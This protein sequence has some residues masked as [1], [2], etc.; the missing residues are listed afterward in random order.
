MCKVCIYVII[1]ISLYVYGWFAWMYVYVPYLS[2][3]PSESL[4]L[5][6][7]TDSCELACGTE[8]RTW[9][10]WKSGHCS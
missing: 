1:I 7:L 9:V 6:L 5:E 2:L 8:K 10:L 4:K 3:V